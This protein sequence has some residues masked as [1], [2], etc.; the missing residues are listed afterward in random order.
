MQ[1]LDSVCASHPEIKVMA[2]DLNTD[3][4]RV[5]VLYDLY[6]IETTPLIYVLDRDKRIIA[7]KIRAQQIPLI[8]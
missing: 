5:D 1:D 2:I 6:D 3:D 8:L 4:A 7:K